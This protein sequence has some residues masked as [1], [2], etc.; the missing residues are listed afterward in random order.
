MIPVSILGVQ[1][2][3]QEASV[4]IGNLDEKVNE[5]LIWEIMLQAGP[6]KAVNMPRDRIT[7]TH[8]GYA[9]CEFSSEL[10]ADYAAKVINQIRIYGKSIKVNRSSGDRRTLDVGAN[11]FVGNLTTEVDEKLLYDTFS[12]FGTI[13]MAPT[14]AKDP[15]TGASRGFGFVSFDCFEASDAAIEAMNG[16]Y[17]C[18]KPIAVS[19][20]FK[21]E[22]S[23]E[24]HG[25]A[26]ERLLATQ[27]KKAGVLPNIQEALKLPR[28]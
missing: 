9:F 3:N 14:I 15:G 13:I 11:L 23:G 4:Y 24:R 8:Q 28:K 22:G 1:E 7:G 17:L 10:D 12:V 16:Q 25:S 19:Y 27:G 20:A 5:S 6:V 2:K 18:N 26:A 21:K